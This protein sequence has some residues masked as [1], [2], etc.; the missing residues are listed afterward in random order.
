[1]DSINKNQPE[2]N[3]KNLIGQEAHD[4]ITDLAK[5]AGS[6]F[7]CTRIQ[8]GQAFR[9]RPMAAEHIDEEGNFWFL[10]ASDS[11]KNR[12]IALD[13]AVQ[14]LFQ[15][16]AHSD[17]LM[18]YGRAEVSTNKQKI[19]ELWN[20]FLKTWFTDGV[21]DPRITVIKVRP[22]EGYY[23]DTKHGMA[24]AMVKRAYGAVVGETYDDSIEG[25]ILPS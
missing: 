15:G 10:S 23:W 25:N 20:P 14:L 6:C 3:F 21:N 2:E 22:T 11:H 5:K 7:F 18:L 9:T 13:P 1:M 24:V 16:S 4:K 19:E 12:D 8:T 17:F